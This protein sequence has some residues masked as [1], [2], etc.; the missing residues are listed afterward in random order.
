[1][2]LKMEIS[3]NMAL[4]QKMIQSTEI[5]QM[6]SVE[7]ENYIKELAVENPVVDLEDSKEIPDPKDELMKKLEWLG[8]SDEQNRVYYSQDYGN[9][10]GDK[11]NF[12]IDEGEDLADYLMS[13]LIG[14]KYSKTQMEVLNYMALCLDSKGYFT[15][16]LD[17][18]AARFHM[19]A[20]DVGALLFILQGLEPAG[21]GARSLK[22]CLL[23]Q[24]D[25]Q[26]IEDI[27]V[28]TI[29]TDYLE[30]LGKNQLH[31]IARKMKVSTEA[32]A[33]AAKII[34]A[35][36]PKPGSGF[37][38]REHLKYITPDVIVVRLGG[39]YEILLNEYMYPKISING[40]YLK[41]LKDDASKETKNY[42]NEKV[43]QAEWIMSC[44]S[45]RNRTLMNVTKAIIDVQGQ[46]FSRG[47]GN[48]KPMKLSDI[49]ERL[50]IH[51]STV[52][53][54]VRDKYMQCSW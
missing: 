20:E 11:W 48:L 1:M 34:K 19:D 44:I 49:A 43:H 9:D 24:L 4:S 54:A 39:Y 29:V 37:S 30:L 7:L 51:E 14:S 40:Y 33:F 2:E 27:T 41:L 53:R 12:S 36:N 28:R 42:V 5:L 10:D 31:V 22:E 21:V 26:G 52:S 16:S 6:G 15:E 25:R 8:S 17:E 35:L 46:F 3:Q 47:P 38:S 32:V 45:Q 18:V 23:L 13:Q 50:D